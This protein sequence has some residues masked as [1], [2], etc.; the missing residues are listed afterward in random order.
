ML[1]FPKSLSY[2]YVTKPK[3]GFVA[4][5]LDLPSLVNSKMRPRIKFLR[6]PVDPVKRAASLRLLKE[7]ADKQNPHFFRDTDQS[8]CQLFSY[9]GEMELE[10]ESWKEAV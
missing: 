7:V 5:L 3:A 2:Q 4:I 8:K 9:P 6:Y 10:K 1:L